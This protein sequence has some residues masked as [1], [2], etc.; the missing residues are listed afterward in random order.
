MGTKEVPAVRVPSMNFAC[1]AGRRA[2]E[3]RDELAAFQLIEWHPIHASQCGIAG[4]RT[5]E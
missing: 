3:Q 5:G 1:G 4:Y 2:V